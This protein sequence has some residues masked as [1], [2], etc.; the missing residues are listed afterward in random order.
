MIFSRKTTTLA[1][2]P[3]VHIQNPPSLGISKKTGEALPEVSTK[4]ND[5]TAQIRPE[6]KPWAHL[7]AGGYR[8]Q[9]HLLH[10]IFE[11]TSLAVW[12]E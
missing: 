10:D 5:T 8:F 6:P 12:E 1:Q 9:L 2:A 11:L 7:V 3:D 4:G